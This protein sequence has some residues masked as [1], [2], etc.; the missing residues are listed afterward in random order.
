[1][2][3]KSLTSEDDLCDPIAV[4]CSVGEPGFVMAY[5]FHSFICLKA[6]KNTSSHYPKL[7]LNKG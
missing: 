1:M 7:T 2:H 6:E 5:V 4:G 3:R